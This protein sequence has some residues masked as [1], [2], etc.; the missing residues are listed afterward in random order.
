MLITYA[1]KLV[2][3]VLWSI[4]VEKMLISDTLI[5]SDITNHI[6]NCKYIVGNQNVMWLFVLLEKFFYLPFSF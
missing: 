4:Y 3:D 1:I 5:I 2:F 6:N